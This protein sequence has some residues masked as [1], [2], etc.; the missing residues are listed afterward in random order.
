MTVRGA[1]K[2]P[3]RAR[4]DPSLR[5]GLTPWGHRTPQEPWRPRPA[6]WLA[7]QL[8]A[9][10]TA[11]TL[12]VRLSGGAGERAEYRRLHRPRSPAKEPGGGGTGPR[13][14]GSGLECSLSHPGTWPAAR[15]VEQEAHHVP[16]AQSQALP[17]TSSSPTPS[18]RNEGTGPCGPASEQGGRGHLEDRLCTDYAATHGGCPDR[19]SG[20]WA[21][22]FASLGLS[23]IYNV[24]TKTKST[25]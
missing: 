7:S 9:G 14:T 11:L 20:A 25:S 15:A 18:P 24:R 1:F 3:M 8:P 21:S 4:R 19:S 5:R 6:A 13:P 22:P 16:E 23:C 12:C 2:R 17:N 10:D